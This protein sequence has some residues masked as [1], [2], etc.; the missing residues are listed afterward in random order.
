MKIVDLFSGCGGFSLGARQVGFKTSLAIDADPILSFPYLANFPRSRLLLADIAEL[1]ASHIQ[2]CIGEV[3]GIFGGPPCQGFSNI[4]LRHKGDPRRALLLD[5]FRL[6]AALKPV[7]FVMENVPGL[8]QG[9][10]K[11]LLDEALNL[12]RKRYQLLGPTIFDAADFGAATRRPRLFVIGMDLSRADPV[13]AKDIEK[14]RRPAVTVEDAIADLQKP[15][16]LRTENGY[17]VWKIASKKKTNEY[18][19]ALRSENRE[20][21]S[22]QLTVHTSKVT[23]RFGKVPEGGVDSVGRH[24]R[25]AWDGQ[26]A[27]L[28]AGTGNDKGSYQS[29]RPLHPDEPRVITVREAARLQ[30]FPD[31]FRFHPTTWHSFRMIGNSVSPIMARAIFSVISSKIETGNRL[32]D[33]AE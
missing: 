9:D 11:P 19:E 8:D 1:N 14:R 15:K 4:G 31:R 25:L 16:L 3:G 18:N 6:V 5:F 17:D 21:T 10:S 20:F 12:V 7:F 30:G 13:T 33:A 29:V 32:L 27:T 24:P 2:N 28:R 22:P 23:K 26:C